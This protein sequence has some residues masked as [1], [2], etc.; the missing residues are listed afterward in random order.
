LKQQKK[1]QSQIV[2][3]VKQFAFLKETVK[4]LLLKNIRFK[5]RRFFQF[6]SNQANFI[7]SFCQ[8]GANSDHSLIVI[9][10][11][12]DCKK[13]FQGFKINSLLM[14]FFNLP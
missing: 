8:S 5:R 10:I 2:F 14:F 1:K 9:Q 3:Y 12:C 7:T 13:E 11:V 4:S 6:S